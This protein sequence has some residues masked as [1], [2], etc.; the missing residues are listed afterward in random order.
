MPE[1]LLLLILNFQERKKLATQ[2]NSYDMNK[3]LTA[4]VSR[5][6]PIACDF[7]AEEEVNEQRIFFKNSHESLI[8]SNWR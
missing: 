3:S 7:D 2:Q 1:K 6:L 4:L 5:H 8:C